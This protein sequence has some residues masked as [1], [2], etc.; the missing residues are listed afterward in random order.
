MRKL[1]DFLGD[2]SHIS[3]LITEKLW[4]PLT[5]YLIVVTVFIG[6][7]WHIAYLPLCIVM[8][9]LIIMIVLIVIYFS[10]YVLYKLLQK[11][12]NNPN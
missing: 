5:I 10:L 11:I 2:L 4:L 9:P 12:L 8:A 6:D 1:F 7:K 3:I